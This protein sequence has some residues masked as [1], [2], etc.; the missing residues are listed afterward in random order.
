MRYT[1]LLR[2]PEQMSRVVDGTGHIRE[3]RRVRLQEE[4]IPWLYS[5][6]RRRQ[7]V[8]GGS[9]LHVFG[10]SWGIMVVLTMLGGRD[11]MGNDDKGV[12]GQ[13]GWLVNCGCGW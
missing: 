13:N 1:D 12:F 10:D 5:T 2:H 3:M 6:I 8:Q 7:V 9:W 11:I 4:P